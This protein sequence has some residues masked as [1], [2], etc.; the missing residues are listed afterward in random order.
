MVVL[1]VSK[2]DD[3]IAIGVVEGGVM[4]ALRFSSVTAAVIT[5]DLFS[6]SASSSSASSSS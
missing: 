1:V 3:G 6:L 2:D 4:P 5:F